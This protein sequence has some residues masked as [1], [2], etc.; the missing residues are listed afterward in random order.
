MGMICFDQRVSA[1]SNTLINQVGE[2]SVLLNLNSEKYFGLDE[3]GTGM[4]QALITSETIQKAYDSLLGE[5]DV[6]AQVLRQDLTNL[7]EKLL[8]NGLIEINA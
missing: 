1:T 5:Y 2:E 7:I 4:W 8:A 6:D 3:V